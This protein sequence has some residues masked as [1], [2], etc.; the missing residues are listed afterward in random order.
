[1]EI[2]I[3]IQVQHVK[4]KNQIDQQGIGQKRKHFVIYLT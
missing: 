4:H 2:R 1:M 3:E